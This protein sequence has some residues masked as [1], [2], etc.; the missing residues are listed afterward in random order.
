MKRPEHITKICEECENN[1]FKIYFRNEEVYYCC[2]TKKKNSGVNNT[3]YTGIIK[4]IKEMDKKISSKCPRCGRKTFKIIIDNI[5]KEVY[6]VECINCKRISKRIIEL[7]NQIYDDDDWE[8][9]LELSLFKNR[10]Y[11]YSEYSKSREL[12]RKIEERKRELDEIK[13]K[14]SKVRREY[15]KIRNYQLEVQNRKK[16]DLFKKRKK[17]L[18]YIKEQKEK[19]YLELERIIANRKSLERGIERLKLDMEEYVKHELELSKKKDKEINKKSEIEKELKK[20]KQIEK[21]MDWELGR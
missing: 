15:E 3:H 7:N 13:S 19:L 18:R 16:L 21:S 20:E 17:E 9:S 6:S 12:G 1:K 5:T 14:E 11:N 10:G 4:N 8:K 2:V